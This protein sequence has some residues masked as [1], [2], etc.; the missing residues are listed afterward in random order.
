MN[1]NK[2]NEKNILLLDDNKDFARPVVRWLKKEGFFV[3]LVTSLESSID[4]LEQQRFHLAI[5][6]IRLDDDDPN[7]N[8]GMD[9][10]RIRNERG[11]NDVM[12]VIVLTGNATV[13]NILQA[14]QE[15][16][17]FS[18]LR[19]IPGYRQELT[20]TVHRAFEEEIQINFDLKYSEKSDEVLP[21]IVTDIHWSD[22]KLPPPTLLNLEAYDLIG[23]LFRNAESIYLT[24]LRPGLSGAGIIQVE[25]FWV[26]S[27]LGPTRVVKIDRIDKSGKEKSNYDK[28]VKNQ[29]PLASTQVAY[30]YTQHLGGLVYS[31]AED[32][33]TKFDEFDYFYRKSNQSSIENS[34]HDLI[35]NTCRYWYDNTTRRIANL[36]NLYFE[37]FELEKSHLINRIR[38]VIPNFD[39]LASQ[40]SIPGNNET[41]I[42]PLFWLESHAKQCTLPVQM[43]ITHG[44]MTGRNI[45]VDNEGKCWMIDF[46]R[47]CHSHSLR[48]FVIFE[49]DLKYRQLPETS[50]RDFL[51]LEMLLLEQGIS[52]NESDIPTD[53]PNDLKKAFLV[54]QSIRK[55][56]SQ[57]AFGVANPSRMEFEYLISLLMATL[58]VVRLRHIYPDRKLQALNSAVLIC[59]ALNSN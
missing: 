57:I 1:N 36:Q 16:K 53:W 42:N 8:E 51:K 40:I 44:D 23:K 32:A 50:N 15:Y 37:A 19:K 11:L 22:H 54:I 49:T 14:Y 27:G 31:F 20:Q 30:A 28:F 38:E 41:S 48:D 34:L 55:F 59:D 39:P 13:E 10:L 35:F 26:G 52:I 3:Q 21:D 6:D 17:I 33:S 2:L 58:N 45:M 18:Y 4:F 43:C 7:N 47:T 56:A 25:P 9:F 29:L 12:P 24:K 46:L 5:V